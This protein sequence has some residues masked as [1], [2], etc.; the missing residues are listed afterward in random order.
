MVGWP[1][2]LTERTAES[3][4]DDLARCT[5]DPTVPGRVRGG[6]R[7]GTARARSAGE[8]GRPGQPFRT[9]RASAR[10]RPGERFRFTLENSRPTW[11]IKLMSY[12]LDPEPGA[13]LEAG[14]VTVSGATYNDGAARMESVLVSVDRGRSRRSS[15]RLRARTPGINGRSRPSSSL[16]SMRSG[17]EPSTTLGAASRSMARCTGTRTATS[18]PACSRPK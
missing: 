5:S 9:A 17:R 2:M 6:V 3:C 14:A 1:T 8:S 7:R 10:C 13:E 11:Y 15:R 12:I 4:P 16:A 18:G